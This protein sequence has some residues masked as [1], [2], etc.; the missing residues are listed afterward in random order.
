VFLTETMDGN[1]AETLLR[2]VVVCAP[3]DLNR[4]PGD[5]VFVCDHM[6][7]R[8]C[9]VRSKSPSWQLKYTS[10]KDSL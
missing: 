5:D 8:G 2:P 10:W 1:D 4:H 6:Y 7:H 3:R 9:A